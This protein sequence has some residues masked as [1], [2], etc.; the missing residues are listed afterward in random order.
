MGSGVFFELDGVQRTPYILTNY[1]VVEG[2]SRVVIRMGDGSTH[3]GEVIWTDSQRDLAIVTLTCCLESH[4]LPIG[5]S[6]AGDAP[7][8]GAEVI[9]MGFPLGVF[10]VRTTKG[11]VASSWYSSESDRWWI[12]S[13]AASNPGNS[14]GPLLNVDGELVGINTSS[15]DYTESG[16]PVEGMN[17]SVSSIT[18]Q[19]IVPSLSQ[20]NAMLSPAPTLVAR[21]TPRA[22]PRPTARPTAR[23]TPARTPG[24][25]ARVPVSPRLILA[26]PPPSQEVGVSHLGNNLT[27][28]FLMQYDHLIAS[29]PQTAAYGPQL[30]SSWTTSADGKTW[31][32][33][34][35]DDVPFY[36]KE[37]KPSA[38]SL[39]SKDVVWSFS[40][41]TG[42]NTERAINPGYW[43]GYIGPADSHSGNG[44]YGVILA[45]PIVN[46]DLL[47]FMSDEVESGILSKDHWDDVGGEDGYNDNP[48][49][50]GPFTLQE[51]NLG[52]NFLYQRVEDHWRQTPLF[53]EVELRLVQESSTRAALLLTE[54]SHLAVVPRDIHDFA[55]AGMSIYRASIP[56]GHFNMRLPW[57]KPQNYVKPDG[58]KA[59][60]GGP[61]G[62]T[63]GYDPN[64]PLRDTR[65]RQALIQAIDRNE[66]NDVFFQGRAI[67]NP[68][69]YLPPWSDIFKD[70]WAPFPGPD[71]ATGREGGWDHPYDVENAK[72][73]LE[74]AGHAGGGFTMII[75][76]PNNHS[77]VPEM[78]DVAEQISVY[79]SAI[80][81]DTEFVSL[82]NQDVFATA[83]RRE[84]P[85]AVYMN[86]SPKVAHP[87]VAMVYNRYESGRGFFDYDEVSEYKNR[88]DQM[89]NAE[90][91]RQLTLDFGD[92][93]Y[94][95]TVN[96]PILWV[97]Q[98]GAYNPGVLEGYS[99]N[100][101]HHAPV[102]YHEYTVP[103]YR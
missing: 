2:E 22:T 96:F 51:L 60:S 34:L 85:S 46:L 69:D 79:W 100:L 82:T 3:D 72:K 48:M 24:P 28:S 16:R 61:E 83:W 15:T 64:D 78:P 6:L 31:T 56:A 50:N 29:D 103:V 84:K 25:L 14:G 10:T 58:S 9:A 77:L 62:P 95:R 17:Y 1:H 8:D 37:G 4:L 74:E 97:F 19:R 93:W 38:Y 76:V 94:E 40:L 33:Q 18:I 26:V 41:L 68:M 27:S 90:E 102:R 89:V 54:E 20:L 63:K 44:D 35:R 13:D 66:I 59:Y 71:G 65:V 45:M 42:V 92:W 52:V 75:H 5:I 23:P 101:L 36:N 7:R 47:T 81:V 12:Q 98:E 49:G 43:E 21:A 39:T 80:G 86:V 67:P 32:F 30:A 73:L 87:C 55:A 70:E 88:C 11:I 99:V 57:Y 53:H 91:R